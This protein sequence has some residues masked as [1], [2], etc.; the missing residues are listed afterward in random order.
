VVNA[1]TS[2]VGI[3]YYKFFSNTNVRAY[4]QSNGYSGDYFY[5]TNLTVTRG[6]GQVSLH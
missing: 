5:W 2:T 6:S 3:G 4:L 1:G